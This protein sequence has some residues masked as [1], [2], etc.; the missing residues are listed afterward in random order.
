[1]LVDRSI[2][3]GLDSLEWVSGRV[4]AARSGRIPFRATPPEQLRRADLLVEFRS[5]ASLRS[6]VLC[7]FATEF[8]DVIG[9]AARTIFGIG[10][11]AHGSDLRDLLPFSTTS[12]AV[13][14]FGARDSARTA[15][16]TRAFWVCGDRFHRP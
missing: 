15:P 1:M 14:P 6:S 5:G 12:E 8:L 3:G 10:F 11:A 9:G 16:S 2:G 4:L 13:N 7:P